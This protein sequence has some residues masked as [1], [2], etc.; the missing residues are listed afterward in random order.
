L[1]ADDNNDNKQYLPLAP[2]PLAAYTAA[3]LKEL[4]REDRIGQR[5]T[6]TLPPEAEQLRWF[7]LPPRP[8]YEA[9]A[10]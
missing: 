5:Y 4:Q 2:L 1:F 10:G 7:A 8:E 3:A 6:M 9:L